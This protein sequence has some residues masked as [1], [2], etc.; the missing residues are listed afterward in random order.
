[1]K[2]IL[3]FVIPFFILILFS[4]TGNS[5]KKEKAS[6]SNE[7]SLDILNNN[8]IIKKFRI[9]SMYKNMNGIINV[10]QKK[11]NQKKPV[12]IDEIEYDWDLETIYYE[13]KNSNGTILMIK[14]VPYDLTGDSYQSFTHYF[15]DN[16]KTFSFEYTYNYFGGNLCTEYLTYEK[17]VFYYDEN[18]KLIKALYRLTDSKNNVLNFKKCTEEYEIDYVIS[19]NYSDFKEKIESGKNMKYNFLIK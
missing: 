10:L 9:D 1:M 6:R 3:P 12:V 14:E 5:L 17:R 18:F 15:D 2:I 13:L 4:C 19:K 7:V 11:R 16:G 8:L